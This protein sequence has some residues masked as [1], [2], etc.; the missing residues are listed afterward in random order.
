MKVPEFS[1]MKQPESFSQ[2]PGFQFQKNS[3]SPSAA[4]FADISSVKPLRRCCLD[5]SVNSGCTIW[6]SNKILSHFGGAVAG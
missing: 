6:E 2:I 3:V 1:L 5:Q 4:L